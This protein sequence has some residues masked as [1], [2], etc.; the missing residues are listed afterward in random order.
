ML[1][2]L[3]NRGGSKRVRILSNL[4]FWL[5]LNG[6]LAATYK[7]GIIGGIFQRTEANPEASLEPPVVSSSSSSLSSI[8]MPSNNTSSLITSSV[9]GSNNSANALASRPSLQ[10]LIY[11]DDNNVA[12]NSLDRKARHIPSSVNLSNS[13]QQFDKN[14]NLD[15]EEFFDLWRLRLQRSRNWFMF[16]QNYICDSDADED[17]HLENNEHSY[18]DDKIFNRNS[19]ELGKNK[20]KGVVVNHNEILRVNKSSSNNEVKAST[21]SESISHRHNKQNHQNFHHRLQHNHPTIDENVSKTNNSILYPLSDEN[22]PS[23]S[24]SEKDFLSSSSTH[25]KSSP[26]SRCKRQVGKPKKKPQSPLVVF[27][28]WVFTVGIRIVSIN[29]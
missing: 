28:C 21:L 6:L 22:I 20:F 18:N 24:S 7:I 14:S 29:H 2:K 23:S 16:N 13:L 9:V 15:K 17:E 25:L 4:L 12:K 19:K 11:D 5:L 10:M 27:I 3:P 8:A 1:S 26:Q